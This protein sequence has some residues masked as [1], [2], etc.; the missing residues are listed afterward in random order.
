MGDTRWVLVPVEATE[1]M[2]DVLRNWPHSYVHGVKSCADAML[3]AAPPVG[4]DV[5]QEWAAVMANHWRD[6]A[7]HEGKPVE[8]VFAGYVRAI[9]AHITKD[10]DH[11]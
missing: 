10:N 9:L 2:Q 1:E 8:E 3:A 4:E 11:G 6:Q 5:V 7:R